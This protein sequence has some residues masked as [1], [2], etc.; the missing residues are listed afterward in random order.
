MNLTQSMLQAPYEKK[1]EIAKQKYEVEKA[2]YKKASWLPFVS[3]PT[4]L[5]QFC[6]PTVWTVFHLA[7]EVFS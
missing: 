3:F 7:E 2:A 4:K 6:L 1:A 5:F